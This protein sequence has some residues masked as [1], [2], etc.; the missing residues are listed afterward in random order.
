[1]KV[2]LNFKLAHW[3]SAS[4][5]AE[6]GGKNLCKGIQISMQSPNL[7]SAVSILYKLLP[8]IKYKGNFLTQPLLNYH[9]FQISRS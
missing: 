5:T 6:T 4:D 7:C 9:E 3:L 2:T 8:S 1:M